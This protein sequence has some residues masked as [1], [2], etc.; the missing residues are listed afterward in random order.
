MS[1]SSIQQKELPIEYLERGRF[2][3]RRYFDETSLQELANSIKEHGLIEP[4]VVREITNNHYEIIAGERRW[5][6]CQLA[7]HDTIR[8]E[9]RDLND[10]AAAAITIIENIQ[11]ENLNPIEEAHGYQRLIDEFGYMHEEVAY[12]VGKSRTKI[13]N[14]LRL[15]KLDHKIQEYLREGKISEGHGKILAG[16]PKEIQSTLGHLCVSRGWSIRKLEQEA[17]SAQ[18]DTPKADHAKDPNLKSIENKVSEH[19]G[20]KA[21]IEWDGVKGQLIINW[22]DVDIFQGI[23]GKMGLQDE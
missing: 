2:Q 12:E 18:K 3:P 4:V 10:E 5:R 15:L 1:K 6:A 9:V 23:L 19:L 17:K 20:S 8:C 7:G 21:T 16:L 13:T 22:N 14:S 11:R